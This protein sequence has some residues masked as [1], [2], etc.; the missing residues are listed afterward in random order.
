M[1]LAEFGKTF[2]KSS[3]NVAVGSATFDV[4]PP[5][6]SLEV[7]A[8]SAGPR[9]IDLSAATVSETPDSRSAGPADV[10]RWHIGLSVTTRRVSMLAYKFSVRA[11]AFSMP[12][13]TRPVAAAAVSLAGVSLTPEPPPFAA[14]LT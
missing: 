9:R 1:T 14:A 3:A 11:S 12:A 13:V 4:E 2:G 6:L 10:A 5:D 8:V 7:H